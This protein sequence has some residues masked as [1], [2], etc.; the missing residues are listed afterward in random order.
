LY[1]NI[2]LADADRSGTPH[3]TQALFG[4]TLRAPTSA[5][6]CA[7]AWPPAPSCTPAPRPPPPLPPPPPRLP[8]RVEGA[9][10]QQ[11]RNFLERELSRS[12]RTQCERHHRD[13]DRQLQRLRRAA[14]PCTNLA[15]VTTTA[16]TCCCSQGPWLLRWL[17][18]WASASA[19]PAQT[20]PGRAPIFAVS[21]ADGRPAAVLVAGRQSGGG[22][23]LLQLPSSSG[24]CAF[25]KPLHAALR[26]C[27][28]ILR[29]Q[30]P[31]T[32]FDFRK[33]DRPVY[34][35]ACQRVPCAPPDSS[36][37]GLHF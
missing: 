21:P 27:D 35:L 33:D 20:R 36:A 22:T 9:R 25:R 10:S 12:Y 3:T 19:A 11:M 2:L 13:S 6:W 29:D 37:S 17:R 24:S 1:P 18:C 32:W 26:R 15:V 8:R 4:G 30:L 14:S 23:S 5:A 34:H 28:R 7:T 31:P 16:S